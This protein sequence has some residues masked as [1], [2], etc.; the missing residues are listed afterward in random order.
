MI[1]AVNSSPL[2]APH[3]QLK[4]AAEQFESYFLH[5]MLA[6]MRK[7]VPKDTVLPDSDNRQSIFTDMLD[8][9]MA[10]TL[11]RRGDL[12]IARQMY[13]QLKGTLPDNK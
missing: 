8:Q 6:E 4:K 9:S 13:D 1:T 7:T 2:D 12:G 3:A 5:Q 11:S 10:D